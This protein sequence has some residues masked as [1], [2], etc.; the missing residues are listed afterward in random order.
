MKRTGRKQEWSIALFAFG[1]L[2][3]FPPLLSIFDSDSFV[4]GLPVSYLYLFGAWGLVILAI[5]IGAK[6][7]KRVD[8]NQPDEF[9]GPS[10]IP[11][12]DES[13]REG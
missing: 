12:Q 8:P 4:A 6:P 2:V 13:G 5:A 3:F 1:L 7:R 11:D 10:L 9:T